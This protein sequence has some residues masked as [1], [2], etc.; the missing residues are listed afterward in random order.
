[1]QW[2]IDGPDIPERLL[3]A[4]EDGRVVFFCG[5]GISKPAGLPGFRK[6]VKK[7]YKSLR[8]RKNDA[9][10]EAFKKGEFDA[11]IE[12]LEAR[13]LDGRDR[14]RSEVTAILTPDLTKSNATATHE[15]LLKLGPGREGHTRVVTTNFDRLFEHAIAD[16]A[17]GLER[18]RGREA[19]GLRENWTGMVYLHGLLPPAHSSSDLDR[20]VLSRRDFGQAYL[21]DGWAAEFVTELF[22][23]YTVCFVGYSLGDPVMQ[24]MMSALAADHASADFPHGVF[25]FDDY[26]PGDE[27]RVTAKWEAKAVTPIL[28]LHDKQ[29]SRLHDTVRAWG[30]TYA[31]GAEGK[32]SLVVQYGQLSPEESTA[33]NDF[34]GR[35]LWAL[36]DSSGLPAKKF[37][38]LDPVPS[39][40]WLEP[41]CERRFGHWDL[42]QFGIAPSKKLDEGL[43]FSLIRRPSPYSQSTWMGLMPFGRSE[44]SWDKVM[45]HLAHW[46]TRHLD[47][48]YL[49]RWM[50][51]HGGRLHGSFSML[52]QRRLTELG[53]MERDQRSEEL[54]RIRSNAPSAIP[55]QLMRRIWG[56]ILSGRPKE[57]DGINLRNWWQ[58]YE[59]DGLTGA[60]RMELR[61]LMSPQ[62]SF[63][64]SFP[65]LD[66]ERDPD[67]DDGTVRVWHV[68]RWEVALASNN[69]HY[70]RAELNK[71]D[72]WKALLPELLP[73]FASLLRD[74]LDLIK[75]LGGADEKRDNS[76]WYQPS[77][78]EHDQNRT[79]N[80]WT[81]L[82]ELTRDAWLVKA[83]ADPR[84]A[85]LIA[86]D[87]LNQPYPVF[88]R[89]C[90]F[91]ATQED[92]ISKQQA[93][94]W[95]LGDKAWWLW[96]QCTRREAIRL[97]VSLARRLDPPCRDALERKLL[98]GPP[99]EMYPKDLEQGEFEYRADKEV[100]IRLAKLEAAGSGLG[101]P[102]RVRLEEIRS[103]HPKWE[104][105]EGDRDEFRTWMSAGDDGP[106]P[107]PL[108]RELDELIAYLRSNPHADYRQPDDWSELCR[109][110]SDLAARALCALAREDL[111]LSER[112]NYALQVWWEA[113]FVKDT[114][115]SLSPFTQQAPE[116]F[117]REISQNA[118]RWVREA[119]SIVDLDDALFME[120]CE[121]LLMMEHAVSEGIGDPLTDAINHPIGDMT[122]GLLQWWFRT[123]P[124]GG[125]GLPSKLQQIFSELCNTD[126][127][128]FRLARVWLAARANH[129]FRVDPDWTGENLCP[130]F[131][132][133]SDLR[134]AT[135]VWSGFLQQS[136]FY[137]PFI[138]Q[139]M[140][141]FFNTA[142]HYKCLGDHRGS[143][144][145]G[146]L[147]FA[148]LD[149]SGTFTEQA[150]AAATE[151]LPDD[152]LQHTARLLGQILGS[153]DEDQEEFWEERV[154]PYLQTIW[155]QSN[156]P[157][158]ELVHA[159]LAEVFVL[160]GNKFPD[161]IETFK[162]W[163][164]PLG[165]HTYVVTVL[166]ES[167]HCTA[168]PECALKF[169]H[170][171]VDTGYLWAPTELGRCLQEISEANE[172]LQHDARFLRLKEHWRGN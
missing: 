168:N 28:Y 6:L 81:A 7:I 150:L 166:H 27:D 12:L 138:E 131:D 5:A 149:E 46:L 98:E 29:H 57:P 104:M 111:W 97:I 89:L 33:E 11:V 42:Q 55:R 151:K 24:Y 64:P 126:I 25:A 21:T 91:A 124:E 103:L 15:A 136:H 123:A 157:H 61:N 60:L 115:T 141:P 99:R 44:G 100:W 119:G 118:A 16:L 152:G 139:I 30:A 171:V 155:P 94:D 43:S 76:D 112:W 52:I 163:L 116:E 101:E 14:V 77:I 22:R 82:I 18:F 105:R 127:A 108:P 56:L 70:W 134:E 85:R 45:W 65:R 158:E 106:P 135:G 164:Q 79:T 35:L 162:H 129:L 38:E 86:K 121:Q 20:L 92:V 145:A 50:V 32:E 40:D 146:F 39:L 72:A 143:V 73:V 83:E 148:A 109:E 172:S 140:D 34:V 102:A 53:E 130:L 170:R 36:S 1:M 169:L 75:D 133:G 107:I 49:V 37:A 8:Q 154:K 19:A 156:E 10:R 31:A 59:C 88:K 113:P 142:D 117:L 153:K 74:A 144:Y 160:A 54:E 47:D 122:E 67:A 17:L 87:W 137:L 71:N 96:S 147:L 58:R 95:L 165:A 9:E 2:V 4:H 78:E 68:L 90:F 62:V 132:W 41:V 69:V 110:D 13:I 26:S 63:A 128:Q 114:W 161:A 159:R 93:V 51:Q 80:D 125:Q 167:E 84:Q 66:S 23:N 48:P 120:L 3:Q